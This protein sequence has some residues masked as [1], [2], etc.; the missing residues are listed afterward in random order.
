METFPLC[1]TACVLLLAIETSQ[2]RD[3]DIS[4][5]LK[6]YKGLGLEDDTPADEYQPCGDGFC[7]CSEITADCSKHYGKLTYDCN[8]GPPPVDVFFSYDLRHLGTLVL[9]SNHIHPI[10]LTVFSSLVNLGI[11]QLHINEIGHGLSTGYLPRLEQLYLHDNSLFDFPITCAADGTSLFPSLR[12]LDLW[13]NQLQ[14][15]KGNVCLPMLDYLDLSNNQFMNLSTGM[16]SQSRF[17]S[18]EILEVS[19]D[20]GPQ[21]MQKNALNNP[22]LRQLALSFENPDT[23]ENSSDSY[24]GCTNLVALQVSGMAFSWDNFRERTFLQLFGHLRHLKSLDLS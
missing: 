5:Q 12:Y 1:L 6:S 16:F 21:T 8:L 13:N 14:F 24:A 23:I 15:I 9:A 17:P 3:C 22:S 19:S 20:M 11:L 10:N 7:R 2:V 4:D 18:L